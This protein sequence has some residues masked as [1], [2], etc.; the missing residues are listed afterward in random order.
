M[1]GNQDAAAVDTK[2]RNA[3]SGP[4]KTFCRSVSWS[5][6]RSGGGG[7]A[8]E[9]SAAANGRFQRFPAPL[10]PRSHHSSSKARSSPSLPPLQVN[11]PSFDQWPKPGSDDLGEWLHP[12]TPGGRPT[13]AATKLAGDLKVDL[14]SL[15][16][17]GGRHRIARFDKE[18]SKVADHIYVGGDAVARD[19]EILRQN[20]I[21]HILNCVGSSCSEYFKPDLVYKTLWLTD[22]PS[23][24]ITSILYDV[25]D[26][27]EEV[28][29]QGGRVFV[30][31]FQGVSRSISLVIAYVMWRKGQSFDDAFRLVKAARGIANPNV[32]FACQL[33]ECQKRVNEIPLSPNSVVRMY[34]MRPHSAY[35]PL[36]LVPKAV[37]EPSPLALDSRGAFLVHVPSSIFVWIGKNCEPV[38]EKDAKA[39]ACQV[40]RYENVHG[41]IVTVQEGE[42]PAEFWE[43]FSSSKAPADSETDAD[44]GEST[45]ALPAATAGERRVKAYDAD[46]ELFSGAVRGGVVPPFSSPGGGH[47]TQVPARESNWS[48]LRRKFISGAVKEWASASRSAMCRVYSDSFLTRETDAQGNKVQHLSGDSSSSPPYLSPSSI[49]S[50]CSSESPSL[51]PCTPSPAPSK[52]SRDPEPVGRCTRDVHLV[53]KAFDS[54]L[55]ERRGR[56][57]PLL[58]LPTLSEEPSPSA[59][60]AQSPQCP[61]EDDDGCSSISGTSSSISDSKRKASE[62]KYTSESVEDQDRPSLSSAGSAADDS[63]LRFSVYS[64]PGFA[65]IPRFSRSDLDSKST[66][67]FLAPDRDSDAPSGRVLYL[68]VG[69][70]SEHDNGSARVDITKKVDEAEDIEWNS[71]AAEFL[72]SMGLPL[73]TPTKVVREHEPELLEL[74]SSS[75]WWI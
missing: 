73:H 28:R 42:E 32:G 3:V 55:A 10:T 11:R 16:S 8:G 33:L 30:H 4:H 64:W 5:P 46:Y 51:S 20:G 1:G 75:C 53:S 58:C 70:R 14:P 57:S 35:D 15:P 21:T 17:H 65:E 7:D 50:K 60:T 39:A 71:V 48:I 34:R 9:G 23:E 59:R 62:G 56:F 49:S 36:H 27:F 37:R 18:C 6:A 69:S 22:S 47:E 45:A 29:E 67:L 44:A 72:L 13:A 31:C 61:P 19:R 52:P 38:M 2:A 41:P 24:D 12:S 63:T 40:V 26:Y 43:A 74:L 54:S 66:F 68:W 25:F